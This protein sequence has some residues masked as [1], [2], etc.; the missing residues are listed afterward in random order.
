MLN[1][2]LDEKNELIYKESKDKINEFYKLWTFKEAIVKR[3]GEGFSKN[4]KEVTYHPYL[5]ISN[6]TF[7]TEIDAIKGYKIAVNSSVLDL[8]PIKEIKI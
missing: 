2:I 3:T 5:R 6:G 7:L 8:K 4:L 1:L